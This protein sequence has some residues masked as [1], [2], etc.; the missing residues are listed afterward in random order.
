MAVQTFAPCRDD[1]YPVCRLDIRQD[2]KFSAGYGY[3]NTAFK[4]EP[5]IDKDIRP[6][7]FSSIF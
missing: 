1:H 3:P 6:E 5:G 2:S 4:Q 7:T